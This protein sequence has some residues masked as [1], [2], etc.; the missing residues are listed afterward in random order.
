MKKHRVFKLL[1]FEV[2]LLEID[3]RFWRW[4]AHLKRQDIAIIRYLTKGTLQFRNIMHLN[5]NHLSRTQNY[6]EFGTIAFGR[7]ICKTGKHHTSNSAQNT[8]KTPANSRKKP[9]APAKSKKD[10]VSRECIVKSVEYRLKGAE[11][12]NWDSVQSC[13]IAGPNNYQK[14]TRLVSDCFPQEPLLVFDVHSC[15]LQAT[16]AFAS[17]S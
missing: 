1:V 6:S 17:C 10:R 16:P 9:H 5:Q 13:T 12:H 15:L 14:T 3:C 8:R 2:N 11:L 4:F 7:Q